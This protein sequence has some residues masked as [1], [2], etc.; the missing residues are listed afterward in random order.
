MNASSASLRLAVRYCAALLLAC[1]PLWA[2][3]Q[4]VGRVSA[5]TLYLPVYSHI[6]HGEIERSGSPAKT[7]VSVLVSVRNTDTARPMRVTAAQYFDT[8]GQRIKEFVTAP[9]V[10]PP[11]GTLEL[12]VP[13]SEDKGGSGAN[14]LITW[15]AD[16]PI[17]PPVVEALHANLPAGRS[18][19]FLTQARVI[20][21]E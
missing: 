10:I 12:Y 8:A 4:A 11:M 21:S 6:L 18:I 16:A 3:A 17:N 19:V 9:R 1:L 15:K 20:Q 5:Q 13:T 7:L 2:G 14:F